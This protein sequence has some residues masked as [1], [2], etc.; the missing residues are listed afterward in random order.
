VVGN[1]KRIAEFV[2]VSDHFRGE[3]CGFA[4]ELAGEQRAAGGGNRKHHHPRE[5]DSEQ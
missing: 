1:D 4:K 2:I 5:W 3:L